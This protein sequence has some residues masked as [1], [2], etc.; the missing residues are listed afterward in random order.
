MIPVDCFYA[1]NRSGFFLGIFL[2]FPQGNLLIG[3]LEK[4]NRTVF[5]FLNIRPDDQ[6]AF[7]LV[8]AAQV[9]QV[10]LLNKWMGAV[11]TGGQNVAGIENS[12]RIGFQLLN[13]SLPVANKQGIVNR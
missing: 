8:D 6:S 7:L 13:K 9:K 10:C 12:H 11:G 3:L 2:T 1:G 5:F 4:Q